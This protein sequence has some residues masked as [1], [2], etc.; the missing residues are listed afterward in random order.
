MES[1]IGL[2]RKRLDQTAALVGGCASLHPA[3]RAVIR[4]ELGR[5]LFVRRANDGQWCMPVGAMKLSE[6]IGESVAR[7]VR[8]AAGLEVLRATPLS[9]YS[10]PRLHVYTGFFGGTHH[11]LTIN[12]RIEPGDWFGLPCPDGVETLEARFFAP[13][14]PALQVGAV[15]REVLVDLT[16]FGRWVVVK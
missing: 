16:A 4:D 3:V 5:V 8:E 1:K 13:D 12:F 7:T 14:A 11:L 6:S 9:I 2:E 10:D 15:E